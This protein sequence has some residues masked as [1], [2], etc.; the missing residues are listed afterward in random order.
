[1]KLHLQTL[2]ALIKYIAPKKDIRNAL[3]HV[4]VEITD[5]QTFYV[6]SDGHKACLFKHEMY[7]SDDI[8]TGQYL[9][10][11]EALNVFSKSPVELVEFSVSDGGNMT[12]FD[13][14]LQTTFSTDARY[15]DWRKPLHQIKDLS[16]KPS[17]IDPRLL[18]EVFDCYRM[19]KW[20]KNDSLSLSLNQNGSGAN[21]V[22]AA[23][24]SNFVGVVMPYRADDKSKH[25]FDFDSWISDQ[26]LKKAA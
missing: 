8:K 25:I 13:N 7:D 6:A 2:K 21:A 3:N 23:D 11:R 9:I 4:L 15:P 16:G 17:H 18:K 1:M 24:D 19:S 10:P 22:T 5:A 14:T 26:P 20:L 12:L